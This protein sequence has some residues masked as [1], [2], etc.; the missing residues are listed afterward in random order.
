MAA[1]SEDGLLLRRLRWALGQLQVAGISQREVARRIGVS[2]EH[3]SRVCN[4]HV[5]L[6][7]KVAAALA[8]EFGL[9]PEWLRTGKEPVTVRRAP[10][11]TVR[12]VFSLR[13]ARAD[14]EDG[15]RPDA[16]AVTANVVTR[17]AHYCGACDERVPPGA[18]ACPHCGAL[19]QWPA[20]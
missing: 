14:H 20:Q 1:D 9:Q 5:R 7:E 15:H 3:L 12:P 18:G 13:G 19:L 6:S 4:G 11:G 8:R 10:D 16:A 2:E 17:P